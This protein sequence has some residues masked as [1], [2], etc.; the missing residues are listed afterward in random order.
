[1]LPGVA[2]PLRS[3]FGY[4]PTAVCRILPEAGKR[5]SRKPI[6]GAAGDS[7]EARRDGAAVRG[8]LYRGS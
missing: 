5:A 7:D 4:R 2:R 3:A 8:L 6:E 1:M